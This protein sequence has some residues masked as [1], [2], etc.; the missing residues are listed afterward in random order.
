MLELSIIV[1]KKNVSYYSMRLTDE[2]K[3]TNLVL[4]CYSFVVSG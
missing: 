1:I 4:A 3:L 2:Q